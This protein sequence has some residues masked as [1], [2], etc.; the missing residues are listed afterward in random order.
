[1]NIQKSAPYLSWII[2]EHFK[3]NI[4]QVECVCTTLAYDTINH[5][6]V[7]GINSIMD[8]P[9]IQT[10][11][12]TPLC[13][14]PNLYLPSLILLWNLLLPP[15]LWM[16][17]PYLTFAS[18]S[19]FITL[20]PYQCFM[21]DSL[22]KP[23][24]LKFA[25]NFCFCSHLPKMLWLYSDHA[26]WTEMTLLLGTVSIRLTE[27]PN[28]LFDYVSWVLQPKVFLFH[29]LISSCNNNNTLH[30]SS[31]PSHTTCIPKTTSSRKVVCSGITLYAHLL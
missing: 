3:F 8:R 28:L 2:Q 14:Q 27:Y 15:L 18:A 9:I 22:M 30:L 10:L 5:H 4:D 17:A 12:P 16:L 11:L 7:D 20:L 26:M 21:Y 6:I 1:M 23:P 13:L 24:H 25:Q 31:T 19:T 29:S